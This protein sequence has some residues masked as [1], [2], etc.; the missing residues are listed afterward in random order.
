MLQQHIIRV[1]RRTINLNGNVAD[2]NRPLTSMS[3][4]RSH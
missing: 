3:F 4:A 1:S 2:L